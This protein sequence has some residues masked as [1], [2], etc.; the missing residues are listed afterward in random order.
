MK[1]LLALF[2]F[3]VT[4]ISVF[5]QKLP[6]AEERTPAQAE[7]ARREEN[8]RIDESSGNLRRLGNQELLEIFP[9]KGLPPPEPK[10]TKEQAKKLVPDADDSAKFANFLK[11]PKTGLI[12]LFPETDCESK[13]VVSAAENCLDLIPRSSFFSFRKRNYSDKK[14]SD[15][16][17]KDDVLIS[18]GVVSQGMIVALGDLPL[19][20]VSINS[21]GLNFLSAYVPPHKNREELDEFVKLSKVLTDSGYNYSQAAPL[22]ENM[23]YALRVT[24]Y[25]GSV[26]MPLYVHFYYDLL[27]SDK[28]ADIIVA[29]RVVRKDKNG[30]VILLWK[31]LSMKDSPKLK[32]KEARKQ[33]SLDVL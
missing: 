33:N 31:E 10:L 28:R 11:T 16:R 27:E 21:S 12:K 7:R 13:Y 20:T 26:L 14:L 30:V 29:F 9:T 22:A 1:T 19:E 25:K 5:A 15:I 2:L 3:V 24:A 18:D 6:P 4:Y 23:T 32:Y 17:L 8:R